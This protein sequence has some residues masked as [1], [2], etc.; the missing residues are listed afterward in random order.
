MKSRRSIRSGGSGLIHRPSGSPSNTDALLRCREPSLG[1]R[2]HF[3]THALQQNPVGAA[4]AQAGALLTNHI[5]PGK[6][7]LAPSRCAV[8]ASR[9]DAMAAATTSADWPRSQLLMAPILVD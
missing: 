3:R 5:A 2:A 9:T 1:A 6:R 7:T 8:N 4:L